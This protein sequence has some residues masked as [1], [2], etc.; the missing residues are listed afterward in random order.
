[1]AITF[2]GVELKNPEPFDRD[3]DVITKETV[4]LSGKRS[5]QSTAEIGLHI[6][7]RCMSTAHTDVTNLRAKIGIK[8]SLVIGSD[9]H[10]NCYISGFKEREDPPGVWSYEVG[11]IR[12]TV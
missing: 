4:L 9:T 11:F 5:V 1:M 10:T 6:S 3:D 12:E 2:D 7:F 8:A